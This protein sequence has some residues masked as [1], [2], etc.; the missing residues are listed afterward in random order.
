MC[1]HL[2]WPI[3]LELAIYPLF[4]VWAPSLKLTLHNIFKNAAPSCTLSVKKILIFWRRW[5]K[6]VPSSLLVGKSDIAALHC[7]CHTRGLYSRPAVPGS[8]LRGKHT[9]YIV[10]ELFADPNNSS[11]YLNLKVFKLLRCSPP[12]P[13]LWLQAVLGFLWASRIWFHP[14]PSIIK[15]K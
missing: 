8:A 13:P 5:I 15:Q 3:A 14:Y 11:Q 9:Q 7:A 4:Y 6:F 10:S 1:V 2:F 12:P